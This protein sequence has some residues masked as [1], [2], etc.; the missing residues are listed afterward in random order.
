MTVLDTPALNPRETPLAAIHESPILS[1]VILFGGTRVLT[2]SI[3]GQITLSASSGEILDHRRDHAKY[4]VQITAQEEHDSV[5]QEI[6]VATAGWDRQVVLYHLREP[7]DSLPAP[8]ASITLPTNPES[9]A[10]T[11]H[12]DSAQ[13]ILIIARRDSSSLHFYTLSISPQLIGSQ[14]LSPHS[15]AW[16]AFT[17]ACI[18]I[19]PTDPSL[20]AIATSS[21]PH[22]KL[23]IARLLVPPLTTPSVEGNITA[24][25]QARA[26][27]ARQEREAA[28]LQVCCSAL[29]AQTQY[30]TPALVWR[31]DGSGVWV[32]SDDGVVRGFEAMTGKLIATLSG[33]HEVGSKIRCLAAGMVE[34]GDGQEE[35]WLVSGGFDQKLLV[36]RP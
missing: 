4:V 30:S 24:V 25:D 8:T 31:P 3:S 35:E 33:G 9:V 12:P 26:D 16:V 23:L 19:S 18:A 2:S 29:A 21:V 14:N 28:A 13:P 1:G 7:C 15:A 10:I 11:T 34:I 32:N 36:W 22:M 6:W 27:L 5:N 20:I 17:P